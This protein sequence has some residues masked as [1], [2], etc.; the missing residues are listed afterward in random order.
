[1]QLSQPGAN[2]AI[3]STSSEPLRNASYLNAQAFQ[4]CFSLREIAPRGTF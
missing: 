3:S 4:R 2:I 1:M